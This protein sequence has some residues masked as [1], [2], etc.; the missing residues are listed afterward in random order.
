M[1]ASK[2]YKKGMYETEKDRQVFGMAMPRGVCVGVQ[3]C[4]R[5]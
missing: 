4:C 5:T 3:G 2:F 1:L